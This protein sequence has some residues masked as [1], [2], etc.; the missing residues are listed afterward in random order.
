MKQEWRYLLLAVGFFSRIPVPALADF[1][2]AELNRAAKFFPL[3]G[4]LIGSITAFNY[5]LSAKFFPTDIA[6]IISMISSIYITG[7]FHE[8]GLADCIDGLGG[9][10]SKEQV[11]Q[12]MQDSRIGSYG[13]TALMLILLTKFISLS[14]ISPDLIPWVLL[15]AHSLSRYA[16]ILV[17]M[18][19][20][21]V[22]S[23]GKAKP[24]A[25]ELSSSEFLLASVF[26]LLPLIILPVHLLWALLPVTLIWLFFS[27]KLKKRIGGYTGDCLG[28]MQQLT[29]VM[30]YLGIL[31]WS[32]P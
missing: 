28:A 11:L 18:T 17:M 24:L 9:G 22:R 15:V 19:Q 31:A 5:W 32:L 14:H 6:V 30:F 21:Y 12:I 7:C 27:A 2:E 23:E 16:A 10:W 8:D 3:V 13:A 4:L 20:Y 26:G 25:T 1:K 29:E